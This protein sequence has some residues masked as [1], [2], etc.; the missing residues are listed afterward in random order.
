MAGLIARR[1]ASAHRVAAKL[2]IT[3]DY[4]MLAGERARDGIA[5]E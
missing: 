1:E 4:R 3:P 2:G 5:S